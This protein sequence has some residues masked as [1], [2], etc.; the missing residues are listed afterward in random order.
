MGSVAWVGHT[1][2][3]NH[4]VKSLL[5]RRGEEDKVA[6]LLPYKGVLNGGVFF[7]DDPMGIL[8]GDAVRFPQTLS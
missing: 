6:V 5:G 1:D 7:H 8:D 2:E 4:T 3:G